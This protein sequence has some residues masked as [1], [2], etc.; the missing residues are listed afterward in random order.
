MAIG[1]TAEQL[2]QLLAEIKEPR[3][4]ISEDGEEMKPWETLWHD[5]QRAA[6]AIEALRM[7]TLA[8]QALDKILSLPQYQCQGPEG[9][10]SA[11]MEPGEGYLDF[12]AVEDII[13]LARSL[14]ESTA[15]HA[16]F[17]AWWREHGE[18]WM[19]DPK[20]LAEK[21]W[22]AAHSAPREE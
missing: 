18:G 22:A 3:L 14:P 1:Y 5:L 2:D 7:P 8:E 19:G 10:Y 17:D 15:P 6:A 4:G 13:K 12:Y 11:G 9:D 16:G 21:A 20:A